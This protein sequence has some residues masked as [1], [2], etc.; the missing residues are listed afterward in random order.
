MEEQRLCYC[1]YCG[2]R[3]PGH[4]DIKI[5]SIDQVDFDVCEPCREKQARDHY[6][7]AKDMRKELDDFEKQQEIAASDGTLNKQTED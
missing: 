3:I 1:Q 2:H 6:P 7:T 5:T 4:P